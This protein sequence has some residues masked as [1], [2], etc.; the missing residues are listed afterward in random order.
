FEATI[1]SAEAWVLIAS[2]RLLS[3]RLARA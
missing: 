2:I 1:A 3:R